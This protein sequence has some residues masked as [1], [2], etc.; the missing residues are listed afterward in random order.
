MK[1]LK[2]S[3][4]SIMKSIVEKALQNDANSTSCIIYYQPKAPTILKK[5]SKVYNDK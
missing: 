4:S 5:F 3:Y 2:K 1:S